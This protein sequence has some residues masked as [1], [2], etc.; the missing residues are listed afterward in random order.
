MVEHY[1]PRSHR[2]HDLFGF[3]DLLAID[4]SR[5]GAVAIQVMRDSHWTWHR[6]KLLRELRVRRWIERGNHLDCHLWGK[7]RGHGRGGRIWVLRVREA[8]LRK[9]PLTS[10]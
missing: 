6:N 5:R 4:P 3:A 1:E 10:G 9:K 2:R 8:R 7:R